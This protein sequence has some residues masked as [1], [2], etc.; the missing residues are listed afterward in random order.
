MII[1]VKLWCQSRYGVMIGLTI[2][3]NTEDRDGNHP[4]YRRVEFLFEC[5]NN[6]S[7]QVMD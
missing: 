2:L 7:N 6:K 5:K 4:I 1:G 3:P